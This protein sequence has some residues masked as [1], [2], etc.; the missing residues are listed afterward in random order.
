M[1]D[2][3]SR[4]KTGH[5]LEAD[6]TNG[7]REHAATTIPNTFPSNPFNGNSPNQI[8]NR[9]NTILKIRSIRPTFLFILFL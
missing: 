7:I 6:I 9:P 4:E 2:I 8:R 1:E 3:L 5:T